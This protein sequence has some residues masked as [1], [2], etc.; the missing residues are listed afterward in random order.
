MKLKT[1]WK[2]YNVKRGVGTDCVMPLCGEDD[3]L[4]HIKE[5][6]WYETKWDEKCSTEGELANYLVKI[7]RERLK[8]VKM[9]IL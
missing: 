2:I 5:C 6:K 7:N 1:Q 4:D 8:K 3:T 9:P